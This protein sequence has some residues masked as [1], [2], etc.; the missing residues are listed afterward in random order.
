MLKQQLS[1]AGVQ[2][3]ESFNALFKY[4]HK[5]NNIIGDVN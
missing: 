2:N 3:E 4:E 1:F 5:I